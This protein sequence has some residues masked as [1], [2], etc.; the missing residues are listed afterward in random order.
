MWSNYN[1]IIIPAYKESYNLTYI[2][3]MF[4]N[5]LK[6]S[7]IKYKLFFIVAWDDDTMTLLETKSY[8]YGGDIVQSIYLWWSK[9]GIWYAYDKWFAYVREHLDLKH[10]DSITTMDADW[11]H[12]MSYVPLMYD[13]LSLWYDFIVWSRYSRYWYRYEDNYNYIDPKSRLSW[14][15]NFLFFAFSKNKIFDKTSGFRMFKSAYVYIFDDRYPNNFTYNFYT[16][17]IITKASSYNSYELPIVFKKRKD[18]ASKFQ[19]LSAIR[20]YTYIIYKLIKKW[21]LFW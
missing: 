1:L 10:I 2:F 11:S 16:N 9:S 17:F 8:Y 20:D 21:L 12:D 14:L 19:F 7:S 15:R 5:L 3:E 6:N 4:D 18:G 13:K